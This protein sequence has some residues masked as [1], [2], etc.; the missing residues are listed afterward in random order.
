MFRHYGISFYAYSPLAGGIL[1]GKYRFEQDQEKSIS[2][3]RFNGVGWDKVYRDRYWK[4]EHFDQLEELKVLLSQVYPDQEVSIPEA[5]YRWIYNHS[6]LSGEHGD[7]VVIGASRL[8]QLQMNMELSQKPP[9]D[10]AVVKF[11][12]NWWNSTKHLCPKYFR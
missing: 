2:T 7:C 10:K 1:T 12:N 11:F 4:K 9:L 8:E 5:A 6:K 3:G